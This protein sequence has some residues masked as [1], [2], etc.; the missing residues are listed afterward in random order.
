MKYVIL[1]AA[2]LTI[3]G[4]TTMGKEVSDSQAA[5][6][7]KGV[8]TKD[9]VIA[10]L[11]KPASDSVSSNGETVIVYNYINATARPETFIPIIGGFVGGIDTKSNMTMFKFGKDGKLVDY[12]IT[13]TNASS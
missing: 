5:A 10:A 3:S 1:M 11:G 7:S 2:I 9:Q 8:T 12:N 6:F 4:C 13:K